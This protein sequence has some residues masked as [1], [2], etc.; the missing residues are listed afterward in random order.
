VDD[1]VIPRS[2]QNLQADF[3]WTNTSPLAPKP[4]PVAEIASQIFAG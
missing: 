3:F 2:G 1:P 4:Y